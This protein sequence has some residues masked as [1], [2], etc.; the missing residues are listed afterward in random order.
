MA[1]VND[2]TVDDEDCVNWIIDPN[3]PHF[4]FP[5]SVSKCLRWS[6]GFV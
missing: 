6:G 1:P 2:I 5:N 4:L 3:Q